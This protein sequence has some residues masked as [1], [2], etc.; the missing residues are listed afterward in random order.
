MR[1]LTDKNVEC[2]N[3][4]FCV[5]ILCV[6]SVNVQDFSPTE[7]DMFRA[8]ALLLGHK[9]GSEALQTPNRETFR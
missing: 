6:F 4:F 7:F 8:L 2:P 1:R 5:K 3:N 9:N